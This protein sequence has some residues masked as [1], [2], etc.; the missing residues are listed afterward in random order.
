MRGDGEDG[1]QSEGDARWDG[2]DVDPE[3]H[4]REDD[5]EDAWNVELYEVVLEHASQLERRFDAAE[6]SGRVE[7]VAGACF[8]V[9]HSK[10]CQLNSVVID[11]NE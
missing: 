2:V 10:L 6:V 11:L 8:D 1:E 5:D 3:G 9:V 7:V 4:P